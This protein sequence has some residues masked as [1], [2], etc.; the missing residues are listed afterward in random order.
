[1]QAGAAGLA[2]A[3]LGRQTTL[4]QESSAP[5]D[6]LQRWAAGWSNLADPSE[7]LELVTENIV[8]EDVAV[9][10]VVEG[11]PGF[12]TLLAEAH[13]GIPDFSIMLEDGFT[14]EGFAAAEYLITRTQSGRLPYLAASD[15]PFRLR[16]AS[17]FVLEGGRI[18]RESRY[19]N[20]LSFLGQLGG[21]AGDHLP[22]LGI[23]PAEPPA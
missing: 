13:K 7:L 10:D 1:M 22:P 15:R 16:A 21:L 5:P 23:P 14:G 11:V 3:S 4:A 9:G 2:L 18:Q 20:M 17:V 12:T 19:C 6:L 8:Y